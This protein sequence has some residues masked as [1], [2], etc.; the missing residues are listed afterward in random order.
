MGPRNQPIRHATLWGGSGF[1]VGLGILY[2]IITGAEAVNHIPD[3]N[4]GLKVGV[5]GFMFAG[6]AGGAILS[7]ARDGRGVLP[8]ALAGAIGLGL[9][10]GAGL[11]IESVYIEPLINGPLLFFLVELLRFA[12]IGALT[13]ILLGLVYGGR[14]RIHVLAA[15]GAIGFGLGPVIQGLLGPILTRPPDVLGNILGPAIYSGIV[16]AITGLI[17]GAAL[18]F[19]LE[20]QERHALH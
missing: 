3:F 8:S 13:G 12:I 10:Y 15:A 14:R 11:V 2:A 17:G 18:G 5:L 19:V 9:S 7:L 20:W 4:T 6:A 16:G 1:G